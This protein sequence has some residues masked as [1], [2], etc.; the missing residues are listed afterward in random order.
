MERLTTRAPVRVISALVGMGSILAV[1]SA[2]AGTLDL[3]TGYNVC[4]TTAGATVCSDTGVDPPSGSGTFPSFVGT[5]GGRPD[6]FYMYN[7]TASADLDDNEVGNGAPKNRAVQLGTFAITQRGGVDVF[8]FVLDINQFNSGGDPDPSLLSLDHIALFLSSDG[9]LN[10]F[11][12]ADNGGAGSLGGVAPTWFM[13]VADWIKLD[14]GLAAGSGRPDMY[15]YIPVSVLGN[16]ASNLYVQL[17]SLFGGTS[18]FLNNDGFEEWAYQS[19]Y[20]K[21]GRPIDGVTCY[22]PKIPPPPV[23]EP[24]SLALLGLGLLGLGAARRSSKRSG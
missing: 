23:P 10:G 19:C 7:T 24:G 12:A 13:T 2:Q 15:L 4:T 14:Y 22:D 21:Q 9:S 20:D 8:T 1:G 3:S 11:S 18:P 17:Y 6:T 16:P 5:N